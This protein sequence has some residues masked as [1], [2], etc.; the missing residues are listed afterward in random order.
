MREYSISKKLIQGYLY[1][2]YTWF[3]NKNSSDLGRNI[4]SEV[5]IGIINTVLA[6]IN[7]VV[8]GCVIISLLILLL[9]I[10]FKLSLLIFL[11][12]AFSYF[13]IFYF[14]KKILSQVGSERLKANEER[15]ITA[16]EAFAAIKEVKIRGL[17]ET[18]VNRFSKSAIIYAQSQSLARIIGDV[19]RYFIE[20]ITF[21]GMIILVLIL[22]VRGK[23]FQTILPILT[24]YA[25]AGYRFIPSLQSIYRAITEIRFSESSLDL[26]SKDLIRLKFIRNE[27]NNISTKIISFK[28]FIKINNV[29]FNYPQS[30]KTSLKNI[31]ITIPVFSKIGIVGKTG[32]GKSTLVDIILGLIDPI[33]GTLSIDGKLITN[34]NKR[35]WQK[36]IGYVPQQIYLSDSSV[37][38]NIA[39]GIDLDKIDN[40]ALTRA[41]KIANLHDFVTNQLPDN[42]NTIIGEKG[43]RISGGQRQRIGIARA[44]YHKPKVLI[45]DEATSSLDNITEKIVL[46]S[47]KNLGNKIT[48]IQIAHRLSTVENCDIIFLLDQGELKAQGNYKE[49][50]KI[51]K[52]FRE[53][54]RNKN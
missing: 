6:G 20:G 23:D 15:F 49:L 16:A 37:A 36:N 29:S 21:G 47:L 46:D 45:F 48:T 34:A 13:I 32:S 1:Q 44:L 39:F 26:L 54:L 43:V 40:H 35:S 27:V 2:T 14:I 5:N 28:K 31:N 11:V 33:K 9:I 4:L 52:I 41:A 42:Y 24:I 12:L 51:N 7:V 3:L 10:N 18:Y 8:Y 19:P 30:K 17:E 25:F 38:M 50:R 53:M 22:M